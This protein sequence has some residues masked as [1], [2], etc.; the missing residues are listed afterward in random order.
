MTIATHTSNGKLAAYC[1]RSLPIQVL[2]SAGGFY[3]GT[4]VED[5]GPFT[6]ESIEYWPKREH[7]EDALKHGTWTQKR[8]V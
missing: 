5:E 3:L 2:K 8:S 4:F 7:A 6:R 1:G